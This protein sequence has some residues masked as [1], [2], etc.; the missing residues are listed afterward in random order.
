[1]KK[2]EDLKKELL[3]NNISNFYIFY[4]EDYGIRKHYIDYIKK[5]YGKVIQLNSGDVINERLMVKTSIFDKSTKLY[6]CYGDLEFA[7]HSPEYY[8]VF[9][10]NLKN[11][12]CILI[13]ESGLESTNLF[14]HCDKYITNFPIVE[15]NIAFEFVG[16]EL[17]I[18]DTSKRDLAINCDNNYNNIL[19]EADKIKNYAQSKGVSEQNSYESLKSKNQLL[20]QQPM[21]EYSEFM[22]CLLTHNYLALETHIK[23]AMVDIERFCYSLPMIFNDFLIAGLIKKYGRIDGGSRAYGYGLNWG[24]AKFLRDLDICDTVD[25]LFESAYQVSLMD[26]KLKTGGLARDSALDYFVCT[27]I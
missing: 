1:M 22:N 19:L 5:F 20:E 26:Y 2:I 12:G 9:I 6:I 3:A 24:R 17:N 15:D 21:F 27:I 23:I 10:N 8:G 11:N 13:Y 18:S 25:Y 7:Q 16:S 4:G 14:K